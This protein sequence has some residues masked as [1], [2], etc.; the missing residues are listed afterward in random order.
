MR[1]LRWNNPAVLAAVGV[2][3]LGAAGFSAAVVHYKLML[4]KEP[5]YPADRRLLNT[6]PSESEH[7]VRLREDHRES[8]EVEQTLGTQNYVSREYVRRR[9]PGE[10]AP[11]PVVINFHA[12]YYTGMI[13][14]VPH[15]PDRCFVGGGLGIGK[16]LGDL[17]LPLDQKLWSRVNVP[18]GFE[19]HIVTMRSHAGS[20]VRLPRDAEGIRLRTFQFLDKGGRPFYAGYFFIANGGT[21]SRA[22][23]VR[24]LAFD[25]KTRYSYYLK[26]QFT[27][28]GVNS[29][30][31]LAQSAASMLDELFPDI[32]LCTPDWVDVEQH[33]YPPQEAEAAPRRPPGL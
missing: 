25:L 6:I 28:D 33:L 26:V 19:D 5:I 13:D 8:P 29:G 31:E 30:E 21:V 10:D 17:P 12:A 27:S 15:V 3:S 9:A 7:W 24:L 23:D 32:M 1:G 18:K 2:L 20:Y 22:E 4:H 14:T 11:R 16:L